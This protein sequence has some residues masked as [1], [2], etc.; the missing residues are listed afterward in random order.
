MFMLSFIFV[1][2]HV[3]VVFFVQVF[4]IFFYLCVAVGDPVIMSQASHISMSY[5]VFSELRREVIFHFVDID[6]IVNHHCLN[7]LFI[8]YFPK[9]DKKVL[10]SN[11]G[12]DLTLI[13]FQ[14]DPDLTV[15]DLLK[16]TR[17]KV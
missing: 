5:I 10:Y 3:C 8:S 9:C 16:Y 4:Y 2:V 17:N 7:F 12:P 6:G 13:L 14:N 15:K 1:M 11:A